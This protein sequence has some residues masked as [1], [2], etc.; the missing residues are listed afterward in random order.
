VIGRAAGD[1]SLVA[2][3]AQSYAPNLAAFLKGLGEVG[4]VDGRNVT[5][6][7]LGRRTS[8]GTRQRGA[9]TIISAKVH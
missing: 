1:C 7:Y 2:A 8:F 4:Y 6:E 9:L 3:S 5:N